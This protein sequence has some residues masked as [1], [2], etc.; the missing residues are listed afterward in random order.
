MSERSDAAT[1]NDNHKAPKPRAHLLVRK[2]YSC[3]CICRE[4][5]SASEEK[6]YSTLQILTRRACLLCAFKLN[7][8]TSVLFSKYL[9]TMEAVFRPVF[10]LDGIIGWVPVWFHSRRG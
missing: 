6:K 10:V 8:C 7:V 3:L 4:K 9:V 5:H 2:H 1:Q